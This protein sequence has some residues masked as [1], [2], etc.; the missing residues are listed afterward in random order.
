MD[1]YKLVVRR[2]R[3]ERL[4]MKNTI[5]P[6]VLL[7]FSFL[8][9]YLLL[10]AVT[11]RRRSSA[12]LRLV[13]SRPPG[14]PRCVGWPIIGLLHIIGKAPHFSLATLSRVYGPVMSLRLG[15]LTT[16]VISSPEA[17]REV[18]RTLD[19]FF[20]AQAFSETVRT[21]GHQG[22][23]STPRLPSMSPHWRLWRKIL[24]TKLFSRKC[25]DATKTIR[26]KKVKELITFIV[27]SCERGEAVEIARACFVTSLN[28][29]SNVVFSTDLGSY[30]QMASMELRDSLF[31]VMKIMGKPNLA[32]YFPSIE[33][34]DLQG[35][36]EEM[37]G[38]IDARVAERSSRTEPRDAYS[39]DRDLL[40]SLI[41]LILEDVSEVDMNDIKHFLYD[42]FIAGTETNSTT[43]EWAMVELLRNPEAMANAKVEINFIVGPNRYVR[44]SDLLEFPYLQAVVTETLRLH[45][46]NPFLIPRKAESDIEVLGFLVP[47]NAQILVNAWAIGR[48]QNVWENAERFKPERFLGLELRS[49]GQDFKMIP[50]G[51]GRRMCPGIS[52]ALRIVPHMLA[53]LIYSFEW[54]LENGKDYTAPADLDMNETLGLTLHKASPLYS[55]F[56]PIEK[57]PPPELKADGT[58][59]FPWAARLGPQS[60]NMYREASPT[61]R[62][63][64][65][66]TSK[67]APS[68]GLDFVTDHEPLFVSS[69]VSTESQMFYLLMMPLQHPLWKLLH[70]TISTR[71][72][73]KTSVVDPVTTTP[74]ANAFESPSC[75][76]VLGDVDEAGIEPMGSL[77]LTRG[78][79]ETKPHIKYQNLEWKKIQ[80]RGK[81]GPR[82]PAAVRS[83]R[84]S[85]A[86]PP[87]PP[88]WPI[89][90]NIFQIGKAPH[91]SLA[92]LSRIYGPVMS[93]RFGSLTTVIISSP[94][95]AREVLKTHDQ[96]LSGRIILDPIRSID[97]HDVSMAWL[98]ST[99]P[100]WR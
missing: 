10:A 100:R 4:T 63:D 6:A 80:G 61:Y 75:F 5:A 20:S 22:D 50:F 53:S 85:N 74:N 18:L 26:S 95:A 67:V 96:V 79:R 77:S 72:S 73:K 27:E 71:R 57:M 14:P 76:F 8:L 33:H 24:E 2:K 65:T 68:S 98:P 3:H 47:E 89:I 87:G 17:A 93:L 1:R 11:S 29:I 84:R 32:N 88:G 25:L 45:P 7:M 49:I 12:P 83:Q 66:T 37:K 94:E 99:S 60:R 16:V 59:R 64:E 42:L 46:P 35:I 39:S 43:V 9:T 90:G 36:R 62:L 52:L 56:I 30:D 51:A 48:D 31:C 86:L 34:L 70:E 81:H 41:D 15:S 40:D 21:I 97:H 91:R 54:T 28:V 19:H 92:N 13:P 38:L 82:G 58:L 44:D 55:D 69:D 78:G 23:V